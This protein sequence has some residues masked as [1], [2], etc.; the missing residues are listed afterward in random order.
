[1]KGGVHMKR[2]FSLVLALILL[3]QLVFA[4]GAL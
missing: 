1:M 2:C 4:A 3:M